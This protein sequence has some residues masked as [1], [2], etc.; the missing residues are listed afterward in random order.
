MFFSVKLKVTMEPYAPKWQPFK[1]SAAF[2][3]KIN[4]LFT[5]V[6]IKKKQ[7]QKS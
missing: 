3:Y 1:L 6:F 7:Q 4:F 5:K 2:L